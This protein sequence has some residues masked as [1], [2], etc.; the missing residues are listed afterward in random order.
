M[1]PRA[2]RGRLPAEGGR[3]VRVDGETLGRA[4]GPGDLLE[5]LRR[6]GPDPDGVHVDDPLLIE[7]RGG[8]PAAWIPDPARGERA[9]ATAC[10]KAVAH[11]APPRCPGMDVLA[12]VIRSR[13]VAALGWVAAVALSGLVAASR[14]CLGVDWATDVTAGFALGAAAALTLITIDVG[15][16]LWARTRSR[17]RRDSGRVSAAGA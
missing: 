1:S 15:S 13:A 3:R 4:L 12:R 11:H 7:W 9:A 8:G 17:E 5:F 14:V 16:R 2:A 10:R 6:A